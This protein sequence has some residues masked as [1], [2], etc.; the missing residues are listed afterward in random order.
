[1]KGI[2]TKFFIFRYK[3]LF[4]A[5]IALFPF[6]KG[7]TTANDKFNSLNVLFSSIALFPFMKGITTKRKPSDMDGYLLH[8]TISV[9]EGNYDKNFCNCKP[10]LRCFNHC[11]I[12]VYEGN[13]D[14]QRYYLISN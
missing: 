3:E 10:F 1:M 9:Y 12:S 11:T 6:M 14:N 8:C 4:L 5:L 7:I 2:T 13:Y